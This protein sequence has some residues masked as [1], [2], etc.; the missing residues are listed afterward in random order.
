[1]HQR[2]RGAAR[3]P[4]WRGPS[5]RGPPE[6]SSE[7]HQGV[8]REGEEEEEGL[9]C[10]CPCFLGVQQSRAGR[11]SALVSNPMVDA[12]QGITEGTG[13]RSLGRQITL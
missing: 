7:A 5:G 4:S 3:T 12:E 11:M 10:C 13:G 2:A 8:G 1:M 6:A 9:L